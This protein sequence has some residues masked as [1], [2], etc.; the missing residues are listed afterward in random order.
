[1]PL[2]EA[3]LR[4][5]VLVVEDDAILRLHALDIVEEAGFTAIEARN[6]DEA[7]AILERRSDIA[8]LLTD[9]N[10]PGSMDGVKLAHAVR[11]RWPPIKIVVVS[12]HVQLDESD[13]PANSRFFGKPFEA[14]KMIN[15]L[16]DLISD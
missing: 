4:Y 7:I 2:T 8:L 13:L 6:A 9:V 14:Q 15:E 1:M 16:R 5:A 11:N 10:M 12:G 3:G